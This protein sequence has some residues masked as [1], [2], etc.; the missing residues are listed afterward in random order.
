MRPNMNETVYDRCFDLINMQSFILCVCILAIITGCGD[1]NGPQ[2]KQPADVDYQLADADTGRYDWP[3]SKSGFTVRRPPIF[4]SLADL[5][6]DWV[7]AQDRAAPLW[8]TELESASIDEEEK[9]RFFQ[10]FGTNTETPFQMVPIRRDI[11]SIPIAEPDSRVELAF[12]QSGER[13]AVRSGNQLMCFQL[14]DD[15]KSNL[16]LA[17]KSQGIALERIWSQQVPLASSEASR[18]VA[19]S[20]GE[21]SS[22]M[23]TTTTGSHLISFENGELLSQHDSSADLHDIAAASAANVYYAVDN[24][25]NLLHT[26]NEVDRWVSVGQSVDPPSEFDGGQS[27]SVNEKGDGLIAVVDGEATTIWVRDRE[28]F[29]LTTDE[30]TLVRPIAA[31]AWPSAGRHWIDDT[32]TYTHCGSANFADATNL[33]QTDGPLWRPVCLWPQQYSHYNWLS[34][35]TVMGM[36]RMSDESIEWILWDQNHQVGGQSIAY[37]LMDDEDLAKSNL[38]NTRRPTIA[39]SVDGTRIAYL[40]P[41]NADGSVRVFYRNPWERADHSVE[42]FW[43]RWFYGEYFDSKLVDQLAAEILSLKSVAHR[44]HSAQDLYDR[45]ILDPIVNLWQSMETDS[46]FYQARPQEFRELRRLNR[47]PNDDE[48]VNLQGN[49]RMVASWSQADYEQR[50][51]QLKDEAKKIR[52]RNSRL[53]QWYERG[54]VTARLASAGRHLKAGW[55]ARGNG[56]PYTVTPSGR[57]EFERRCKLAS[58]DAT[59][60]LD[61][62]QP[63]GYAFAIHSQAMQMTQSGNRSELEPLV[64][65]MVALYP[66]YEAGVSSLASFML[67]RWGGTFGSAAS[68]IDSATLQVN[69]NRRD[70]QYGRLS[71]VTA[72]NA[73]DSYRPRDNIFWMLQLNQQRTFEGLASLIENRNVSNFSMLASVVRFGKYSGNN[74]TTAQTIRYIRQEFPYLFGTVYKLHSDLFEE[75]RQ[76]RPQLR[77]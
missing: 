4:S 3:I 35:L 43:Y 16:V 22:I 47:I 65:R 23:V 76:A 7:M 73:V 39:V 62:A 53:E 77:R 8:A 29:A 46:S 68:L 74:D 51:E 6:R 59:L 27:I 34:S 17:G 50:L 25:G 1:G 30:T 9:A 54:S 56:Y 24:E 55:Q 11:T 49:L 61:G 5:D 71:V 75:V 60:V 52:R 66:E 41:T 57:A 2:N 45:Y 44:Y 37:K 67:P 10:A 21:P 63:P 32:S 70:E 64:R 26:D 20:G 14:P 69:P 40:D 12:D 33:L 15:W 19:I 48:F 36:R 58:Q 31:T 13:L 18:T 72:I 38:H 28:R 42:S